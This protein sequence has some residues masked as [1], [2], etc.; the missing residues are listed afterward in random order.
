MLGINSTQFLALKMNL[1]LTHLSDLKSDFH[2]VA[3]GRPQVRLPPL[4]G[5]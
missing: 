5:L 2:G 4:G 1:G 3:H